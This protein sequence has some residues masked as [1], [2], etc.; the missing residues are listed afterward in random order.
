MKHSKSPHKAMRKTGTGLQRGRPSGDQEAKRNELL[1]AAIQVVA[2]EGYAGASL[3]KV[4]ECAGC[5]TGAVTYY[6]ANKEELDTAVAY[7]LFDT[8]DALLQASLE[9]T[10]IKVVIDQWFDWVLAGDTDLWYAFFQLLAH[11]RHE[12]VFADIVDRRY[13]QIRQVVISKFETAQAQGRI[14]RDIKAELLADHISA[15]SDGWM[16]LVPIDQERFAPARARALK[17]ALSILISPVP[18]GGALAHS[19]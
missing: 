14:R 13:A 1:N 2:K 7:K 8:F 5:T 17:E 16:M 4:A 11:S 18:E 9:Q 10:D 6:F 12:P 19:V 15:M 3:R